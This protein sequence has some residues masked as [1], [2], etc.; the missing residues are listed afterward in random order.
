[1]TK[2]KQKKQRKNGFTCKHT[3]YDLFNEMKYLCL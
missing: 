2:M 3:F 1:M